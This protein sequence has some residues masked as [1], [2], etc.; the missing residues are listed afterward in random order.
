MLELLERMAEDADGRI[1]AQGLSPEEESAAESLEDEGLAEWADDHPF[2]GY[3]ITVNG[4]DRLA[5]TR[6]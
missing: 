2:Y 6:E 4:H 3:H 1:G 5:K